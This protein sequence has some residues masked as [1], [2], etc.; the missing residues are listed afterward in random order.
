MDV[1]L[2][3]PSGRSVVPVVHR[4]T[5]IAGQALHQRLIR[6][7]DSAFTCRPMAGAIRPHM[8]SRFE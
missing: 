1:Q 4:L 5:V 7:T 8:T 2:A 6:S 3:Y